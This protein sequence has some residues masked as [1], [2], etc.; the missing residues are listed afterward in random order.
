[1]NS[2]LVVIVILTCN[3][4]QV[5]LDCLQSFAACHYEPKQII[6]VDNGSEDGVQAAVNR[7][8]PHVTVLRNAKNLGAAGGRNTG[9]DY[10]LQEL[11]FTYIMFMDNDIVVMPDF[12][13]RLV[14]GL[15]TCADASVEIASPLL[16]Q[17]G[18]E[19]IIDCAGGAKL[20]FYTGST[21]TR[22]H[23]ELDTGQY[24]HEQFPHCVPTTVLM[25]RK[26]LVRAGRFDVSFDPY[27]YEDLDMVLRAN[28][29]RTPFL[30]VPEAVVFHLGSKT[31]FSGY[32]AEYTRMKG[33]NMRRFFKRHAS[34]MQWYCFNLLLPFLSIKTIVRELRRGNVRAIWGL[35]KGFL[36]GPK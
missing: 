11:D 34:S 21:Q 9:I 33:Q 30:F 35:A 14:N 15:E 26:A 29:G 4:K 31:G 23:G 27:G 1:M 17:M 3:Q 18:S 32:T 7:L 36:S 10:A 28:P 5:T 25:H 13:S 22:G 2:P 19:K 16:Y 6:L 20:N 24:D 8:F 12:L